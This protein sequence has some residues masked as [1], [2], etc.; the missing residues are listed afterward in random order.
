MRRGAFGLVLSIALV[1]ALTGTG[2]H[3]DIGY[4]CANYDDPLKPGIEYRVVYTGAGSCK[5]VVTVD[6][7]GAAIYRDANI[8]CGANPDASGLFKAYV[9][10][11]GKTELELCNDNGD[12]ATHGQLVVAVDPTHGL[13][14][15]LNSDRD[16][17]TGS[18][19]GF[20]KLQSGPTN[21][22]IWC[23]KDGDNG[24]GYGSG[25]STSYFSPLTKA[26]RAMDTG[27]EC[28]IE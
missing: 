20:I 25:F 9:L 17:P 5:Q 1:S 28:Q 18:S 19:K 13:R 24:D 4:G 27:D 22:G 12:S 15:V 14:I 11:G 3:A 26:L 23:A 21:Q 8:T 10:Q 2:A 6:P 7:A 16:Q